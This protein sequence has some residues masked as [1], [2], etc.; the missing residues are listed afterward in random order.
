MSRADD[1]FDRLV[2]GGEPEILAFIAEPVTEELFLDYK[3]SA[4]NGAGSK[5]HQ[6]D[7]SNLAK[8]I[9]GFGNSEGG[10]IVWG[11][12]CRNDPVRGDVPSGAVHIHDPVRF[13]S[14]LEQ[15]TSGLTVPAHGGVRHQSI[16]PG[17]V[18]TLIPSGM[19]APYQVVPELAYYIRAGSNFA[20]APHALLAGMFGRRP[21]PSVKLHYFVDETPSI[22]ASGTLKTQIMM[23]LRN[24]GR[25]VA[26]DVFF[27][28]S[29]R[30]HPGRA[31]KFEFK[32]SE[33]REVWSGRVSLARDT[34]MAM[35]SG[36][37]LAPEQDINP[38]ALDITLTNPIER[39]FSIEGMCGSAEG[40]P[41]RF[42]FKS[43]IADIIEATDQLFRTPAGAPELP[44]LCKKFN[45][46]FFRE[47]DAT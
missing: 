3:R 25:G 42:Q 46:W 38:M 33:E 28:L 27:N 26:R 11:V 23:V 41:Y 6:N 21:Q 47:I 20:K 9:S 14:W 1:L 10:V 12:D 40:E 39:D 34:H 32:P 2:S 30:S 18:V 44:Y 19:H 4:D 15:A 22:I 36:F 13:K 5:L 8:A 17:F 24:F 35:R 31:C 43:Q 37:I 16:L 29:I 7:R 45:K